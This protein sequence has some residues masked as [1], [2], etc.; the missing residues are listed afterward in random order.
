MIKRLKKSF[1]TFFPDEWI[2]DKFLYYFLDE[3][4]ECWRS[5]HHD[6][7]QSSHICASITSHIYRSFA[8]ICITFICIPTSCYFFNESGCRLQYLHFYDQLT[9]HLS[10]FRSLLQNIDFMVS[11][12]IW[13][14]CLTFPI[15]TFIAIPGWRKSDIEFFSHRH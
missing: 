8:W 12:V 10:F 14:N 15:G 2:E 4:N 3:W 13:F 5:W 1:C 6:P 9:I 11:Q 7:D